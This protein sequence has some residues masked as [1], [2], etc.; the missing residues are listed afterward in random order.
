VEWLY[1]NNQQR[2]KLQ[3]AYDLLFEVKNEIDYKHREFSLIN[4]SIYALED[5]IEIEKVKKHTK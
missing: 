1:L 5:A 3:Y 4:T 2:E